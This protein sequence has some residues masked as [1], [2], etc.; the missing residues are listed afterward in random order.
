MKAVVLAYDVVKNRRRTRFFK[1]LKR[2]LRPVQKSVFE[3]HL[4]ASGEAK[5]DKL[6]HREL[7][8]HTDHV[9]LYTLCRGCRATVRTWGRAPSFPEDETVVVV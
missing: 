7:D 6:V 3:G 5:L 1:R 2:W 8:L 9:R 4:D